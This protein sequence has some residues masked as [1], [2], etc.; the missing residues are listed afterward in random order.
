MAHPQIADEGE[1][2]Q[3]WSVTVNILNMQQPKMGGPPAWGVGHRANHHSP[4][5]SSML[6]NV[7]STSD[8]EWFFGM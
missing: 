4:Q 5:K 3:I 6:Q 8:L 7:K 2:L 1:G